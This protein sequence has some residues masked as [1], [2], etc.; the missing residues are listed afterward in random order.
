MS[1]SAASRRTVSTGTGQV[2]TTCSATDPTRNRFSPWRPRVPI[3]HIRVDLAGVLV[4]DRR[5]SSGPDFGPDLAIRGR[6]DRPD[7]LPAAVATCGPQL[8]AEPLRRRVNLAFV[9]DVQA[10]DR[11]VEALGE[12]ERHVDRAAGAPGA[13][14]GDHDGLEHAPA[15]RRAEYK[16]RRTR[17]VPPRGAASGELFVAGCWRAGMSRRPLDIDRVLA[18][19]DRSEASTDAVA[20]AA[21]IA[22]EY[23]ATLYIVHVLDEDVVRAIDNGDVDDD[24][25]AADG[26]AIVE[27]ARGIA[28]DNDVSVSTSVAYG[29]S[30]SMKLRHPGSTVLDTADEVAADFLVVPRDPADAPDAGVLAKAAEY[31]LLYASQ[32][33]LSV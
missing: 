9:D 18:P 21:A 22:A 3:H 1:S 33:V 12:V 13:V 25:V 29:F 31:V 32:P 14:G 24:R 17:A 19:I 5:R 26:E 23:D 7:R 16:H 28:A 11:G 27:T 20:S 8:L 15:L 4:D 30:T 10:V 2:R 6:P